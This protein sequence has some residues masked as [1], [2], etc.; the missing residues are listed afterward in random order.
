VTVPDSSIYQ[1]GQWICIGGAGNAART[2]SLF[3]QVVAMPTAATITVSP[4]SAASLSNAPIGSTNLPSGPYSQPNSV[5]SGVDPYLTAGLARIFNPNEGV[6][7]TITL[8]NS[9]ASGGGVVIV[10]GYDAY[11]VPM[12]ENITIPA[13]TTPV[14]GNKAFKY[15]AS[16]TPQFTSANTYS[17]GP[18]NVAGINLRS[19]LWEYTSIFYNGS[20]TTTNAGWTPAATTNPATATTGD[21][22][23][24]VNSNSGTAPLNVPFNGTTARLTIAMTIR[25]IDDIMA[26]PLNFVPLFGVPQ[27]TQ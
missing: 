15:V 18:S 4:V 19:T 27:F 26:T 17:A 25:L 1:L 2:A 8:V 23:G 6:A 14:V 24:T 16:I 12:S 22:R 21:V 11:G 5:P 13:T 3:T 20:F 7:R 10:R 9:A